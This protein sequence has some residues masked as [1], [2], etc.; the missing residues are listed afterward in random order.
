[1]SKL[2]ILITDD[3]AVLRSGLKL[4]L[5]KHDDIL[6]VGEADT[7]VAAVTLAGKTQPDIVLLD[8]TMPGMSGLE[9]ISALQKV[10]PKSRVLV[11]TMHE[12]ESYLLRA[13]KSGAAGYILKKAADAELISAVRA[14]G[15]GEIYVHS[16]MTHVLLDGASSGRGRDD[17]ED[18]DCGAW[19]RLSEREQEV[20]QLVALGHTNSEIADQLALSIKTIE[21]YRARGMEKLH[22]RSRAAL[23]N[24]TLRLGIL[25]NGP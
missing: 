24:Y 1:M 12:N 15:R 8:L 20:L 6:V 9:T 17:D 11:L 16:A 10:S 4:L 2:R 18:E 23:V 14:V 19:D 7:G 13:L 25:N 5:E 3:H 22:L 21:T